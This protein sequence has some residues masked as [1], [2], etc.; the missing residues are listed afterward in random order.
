M[1]KLNDTRFHLVW[2]VEWVQSLGCVKNEQNLHARKIIRQKSNEEKNEEKLK[3]WLKKG[4][5]K[6]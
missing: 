3:L 2:T 5:R 4:K 1:N 6:N